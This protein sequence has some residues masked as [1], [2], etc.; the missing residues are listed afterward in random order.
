MSF[1]SLGEIN[2]EISQFYKRGG[3]EG[4]RKREKGGREEEQ[5]ESLPHIRWAD[6]QSAS[7]AWPWK[8]NAISVKNLNLLTDFSSM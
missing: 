5:A 3:E 2:E 7:T 8:N 1:N 6:I 4:D